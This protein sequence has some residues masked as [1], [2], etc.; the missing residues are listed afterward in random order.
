MVV[1]D[2]GELYAVSNSP[3]IEKPE[4]GIN[5]NLQFRLAVSETSNIELKVATG[6]G[7]FLRQDANLGDVKDKEKSRDNLG[8]K[9]AAILDVGKTENS[10]TAGDDSRIVNALQKGDNLS[11]LTDAV[12]ARINLGLGSLAVQNANNVNIT[13]GNAKLAMLSASEDIKAGKTIIVNGVDYI[14]RNGVQNNS[15]SKTNITQG[16]RINGVNG[17]L[18]DIYLWEQIGQYL[19]LSLR[20][21]SGGVDKYFSFKN[22]GTFTPA[23]YS[24]FDIRYYS[25]TNPPPALE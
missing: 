19:A 9:G 13:S 16:A 6:D 22:D 23:S 5:V 1:T 15:A 3:A 10:V 4:S 20:V 7:L 12:T 8:L 21:S 24:N 2:A 17:Q 25:A 11:E 14:E 18:A